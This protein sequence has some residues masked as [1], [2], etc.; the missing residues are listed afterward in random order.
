M[1][2]CSPFMLIADI[3]KKSLRNLI[4]NNCLK[5]REGFLWGNVPRWI[6][7]LREII[8]TA[9]GANL[10]ADLIYDKIKDE[11]FDAIGGLSIAAE[12]LVTH[13]L[14]KFNEENKPKK[15]FI[16]RQQPNNFGLR[17]T[18]EGPIKRNDNVILVDDALNSGSSIRKVI[19]AVNNQALNIVS[20]VI[21]LDFFNSG[22]K[23]LNDEGYQVQN[24][25][26]LDDFNLEINYEY[27]YKKPNLKLINE[28]KNKED[29]GIKSDYFDIHNS[30]NLLVVA[31]EDGKIYCKNQSGETWN[32]ELGDEISSPLFVSR[33]R[34]IV[35]AGSSLKRSAL[36]FINFHGKI[37]EK[38]SLR[39]KIT[40]APISHNGYY[41]VGSNDKYLYCFGDQGQISWKFKTEG[42]IKNKPFI[43]DN[44]LFCSSYET[45]YKIDFEGKLI[46]KKKIGNA[47]AFC[48]TADTLFVLA[49]TNFVFA[50][51]QK[52]N[53]KW[54]SD[55]KNK[56]LCLYLQDNLYVGC[57]RGYLVLLDLA[58]GNT[59]EI[60]KI[61]NSNIVEIYQKNNLIVKLQNG[62]SY[63]IL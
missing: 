25:F 20:I 13:L 1:K 11:R 40:H 63:T 37:L 3:K 49:D 17:K 19:E 57:E 6:F 9:E 33:D 8:L 27:K 22:R 16:V 50:F 45:L 18:I 24:I 51:D 47:E 42:P 35:C 43:S 29:L 62:K 46:W 48:G 44:A 56:G 23:R 55:L 4:L 53:I 36:F 32:K 52:G 39:D 34:I 58:T 31:T 26:S 28:S 54:F 5:F 21:I 14:M 10:I 61:S 15:G 12:P 60:Q 59:V 2:I 30:G 41:F 38:I 7:D